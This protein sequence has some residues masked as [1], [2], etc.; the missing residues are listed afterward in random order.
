M[1]G[2]RGSCKYGHGRKEEEESESD[3]GIQYGG[4]KFRLFPSL[5]ACFAQSTVKFTPF[6]FFS[7]SVSRM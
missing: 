2:I 6:Q 3:T 5:K 7:F 4:E 1:Y